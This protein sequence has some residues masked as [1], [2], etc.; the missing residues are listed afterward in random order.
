MCTSNIDDSGEV[1]TNI[2]NNFRLNGEPLVPHVPH[3]VNTDTGA[4][5]ARLDTTRYEQLTG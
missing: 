3:K 5:L 1:E 2:S 4:V